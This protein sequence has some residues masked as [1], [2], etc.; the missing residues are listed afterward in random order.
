MRNTMTLTIPSD[1][2]SFIKEEISRGHFDSEQAAV[3]E[4]LRLLR[5]H[6]EMKELV[7]QGVE[8][9]DNNEVVDITSDEDRSRFFDNIRQR[10]T[11]AAAEKT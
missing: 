7:Q 3:E 2:E 1:L 9:A 10:G 5:N 4:G 8:Q 11:K 6:C